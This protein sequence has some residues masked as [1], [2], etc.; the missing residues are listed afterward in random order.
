VDRNKRNLELLAQ[1]LTRQ[2][3]QSQPVSTLEEFD[4][5][6]EQIETFGLALVDISRFDRKIWLF[7]ERLAERGVPL[8]IL[9]PPH[10]SSIQQESLAHG[11]QGV[12]FKPLVLKEFTSML[13]NMFQD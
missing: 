7:C 13:H 4:R 5:A 2:G 10:I 12:L 6:L 8:L 11:A 1:F 9:S 3:Y